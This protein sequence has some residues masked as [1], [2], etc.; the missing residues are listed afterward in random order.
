[1]GCGRRIEGRRTSPDRPTLA[2]GL[3][4]A[5]GPEVAADVVEDAVE[6]HPQAGVVGRGDEAPQR[7][8]RAEPPVQVP[9]VGRVVAVRRRLE[10]RPEVEGVAAELRGCGRASRSAGRAAHRS[11]AEVVARRRAAQARA[12]RRDRRTSRQRGSSSMCTDRYSKRARR[13]RRRYAGGPAGRPNARSRV[14]A[15][16]ELVDGLV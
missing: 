3:N 8:V 6:D 5:E 16:L 14:D 10:D 1:M 12:G 7:L 2:V 11:R 13:R 4:V 9:V 15:V